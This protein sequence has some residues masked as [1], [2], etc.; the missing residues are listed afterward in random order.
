[1]A[2]TVCGRQDEHD[3]S[4][5][6]PMMAQSRVEKEKIT[7]VLLRC[8]FAG[9][10]GAFQFGW[11]SG[12]IN[13]PADQIK[14]DLNCSGLMWPVSVAAFTVGGLLGA[15]TVG[16]LADSYGRKKFLV[17]LSVVFIIAGALQV[18]IQRRR[19]WCCGAARR[20]H[21]PAFCPGFWHA[22]A[23][24]APKQLCGLWIVLGRCWGCWCQVS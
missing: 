16:S 24:I 7:G 11:A 19:R 9:L 14:D 22:P 15:Q 23:C 4:M 18:R 10:L 2:H 3:P 13:M 8:M 6:L 21:F 17:G 12:A 5:S 1:M 20:W